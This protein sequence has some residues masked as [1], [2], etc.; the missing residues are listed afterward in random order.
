MSILFDT[1]ESL[2]LENEQLQEF[3]NAKADGRL[4]MLPCKAGDIVYTISGKGNNTKDADLSPEEAQELKAERD[5]WEREA[6]K[7][8]AKL[9]EI[10]LLIGE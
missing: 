7:W 8:C 9:G 1:I 10:R 6:K 5:C 3:A 4:V 2:Q